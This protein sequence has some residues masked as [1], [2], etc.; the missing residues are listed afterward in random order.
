[1][2]IIVQYR[3][4][5]FRHVQNHLLDDLIDSG[6]IV[7]FRRSSGW[8]ELG[9]DQLRSKRPQANYD[10]L[11]RRMQPEQTSCLTC[12]ELEESI[13]KAECENRISPRGMVPVSS[14]T[15]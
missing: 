13:C 14:E 10:G 8:V 15:N 6:E 12:P 2:K 4:N 9:K 5:T 7:A 3:D 11:E 1:M